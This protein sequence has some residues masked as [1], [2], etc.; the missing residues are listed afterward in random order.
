MEN[1]TTKII[2]KDRMRLSEFEK[3]LLSFG[4]LPHDFTLETLEVGME[5]IRSTL[6][7]PTKKLSRETRIELGL[8]YLEL[9]TYLHERRQK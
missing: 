8:H 5:Y 1:D 6:Y 9:G 4:F 2:K 7:N 3:K